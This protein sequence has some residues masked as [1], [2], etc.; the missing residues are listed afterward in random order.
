MNGGGGFCN[1]CDANF[2]IHK[3]RKL[4]D[5]LINYIFSVKDLVHLLSG[6]LVYCLAIVWF[7]II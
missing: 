4:F 2:G 7:G 5:Q 1:C 6:L 3:S